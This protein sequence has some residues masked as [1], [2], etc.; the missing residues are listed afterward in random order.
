MKLRS[1][2]LLDSVTIRV[3]PTNS[4]FETFTLRLRDVRISSVSSVVVQT[5]EGVRQGEKVTFVFREVECSFNSPDGTVAAEWNVE[6][7]AGN[8][9]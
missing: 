4:Q 6:E 1:L 9:N 5:S 7:N 8:G 3:V 2:E